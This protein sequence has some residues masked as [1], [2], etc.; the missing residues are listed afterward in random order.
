MAQ[1]GLKL[2]LIALAMGAN[3]RGVCFQELVVKATGIET[4]A[5]M[6]VFFDLF[7]KRG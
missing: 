6:P 4:K 2:A 3:D 1:E 7:Q 5:S